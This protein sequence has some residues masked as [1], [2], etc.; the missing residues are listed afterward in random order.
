[1]VRIAVAGGTGGLGRTLVDELCQDN[2]HSVFVLSRKSQLSF[3]APE[4]VHCLATDYKSVPQL[5]NILE[6][7]QIH[8]VISTLNPPT[9]EVQSAQSNLIQA[10]AQG[11]TA[12]RFVPS[13]WGIDYFT[14]DEHIPLPWKTVKQQAI[15][16]LDKYP[17]LEYTMVHNG[18]FMD[19]YGMPHCHSHMLAEIPYVDIAAA[20]AAIPGSGNDKVTFTYTKDVA[21]FVRK[22]VESNDKWPPRTFIAGDMVTFHEIV[23][24]AE[25]ARGLKFDVVHDSLQD[26]REGKVTEIP[27]YRPIYKIF[28]KEFLLQMMAGFGV[29]MVTGVFA[30][31]GEFLNEKHPEVRTTKMRDFIM[32]HW[33]GRH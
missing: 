4:N 28:P 18:Y 29:A 8:T 30:F 15:A 20:E 17:D 26:L 22:L 27:A 25:Q 16:E 23:E 13:E 1:M 14:D 33:S 31:E 3:E 12:K 19:Y 24:A 21:K 32:T 9:P 11:G 10:A 5:Q 2:A 7:N 6:S